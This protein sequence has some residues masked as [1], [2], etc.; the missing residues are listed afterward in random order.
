MWT[1]GRTHTRTDARTP[2][3]VPSYK[4]TLWAFGSGE[5]K[6]GN[7]LFLK[8]HICFLK[9]MNINHFSPKMHTAAQISTKRLALYGQRT[10]DNLWKLGKPVNTLYHIVHLHISHFFGSPAEII[11]I[12][13]SV[14]NYV[15]LWKCLLT[16]HHKS[17]EISNFS[18]GPF[19]TTTAN[20]WVMCVPFYPFNF[21]VWFDLCFTALQHISVHFERGQLP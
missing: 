13:H 11:D 8:Q 1:H 3:R 17:H 20:L 12:L 19:F 6:I 18:K 10:C 5:L 16:V 14:I 2:A 7:I 15:N 4:L 21:L 9:K